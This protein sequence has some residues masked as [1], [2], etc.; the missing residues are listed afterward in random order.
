MAPTWSIVIKGAD[1]WPLEGGVGIGDSLMVS[2]GGL[3]DIILSE[4]MDTIAPAIRG[5]VEQG[6]IAGVGE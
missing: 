4:G 1:R 5:K 6:A 3:G 2:L